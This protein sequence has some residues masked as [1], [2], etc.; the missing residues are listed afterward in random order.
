MDVCRAPHTADRGRNRPFVI[1][2]SRVTPAAH[3]PSSGAV[4]EKL[5]ATVGPTTP[6]SSRDRGYCSEEQS[7]V[8]E[9]EETIAGF[10]ATGPQQPQRTAKPANQGRYRRE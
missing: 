3:D 7:E 8:P 2:D 9:D 5:E 1:A 4:G 10:V 6:R